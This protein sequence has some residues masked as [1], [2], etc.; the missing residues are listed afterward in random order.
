MVLLLVVVLMMIHPS[1]LWADP[2]PQVV[3]QALFD[4]IFEAGVRAWMLGIGFG[5]LVKLM[6]RS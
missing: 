6:N 5:L 1:S 2:E 3:A 4:Q